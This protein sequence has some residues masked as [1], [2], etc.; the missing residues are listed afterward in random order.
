MT[1]RVI[2]VRDGVAVVA[3]YFRDT[4]PVQIIRVPAAVS[5]MIG[6]LYCLVVVIAV[7]LMS[8]DDHP[9]SPG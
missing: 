3:V 4:N 9:L 6:A 5:G 7:L 2:R 8:S 1:F